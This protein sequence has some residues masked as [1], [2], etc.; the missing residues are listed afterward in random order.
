MSDD[1]RRPEGRR[2]RLCIE[3]K[4]HPDTQP[5]QPA[6]NFKKHKAHGTRPNQ[7][8][9]SYGYQSRRPYYG[10]TSHRPRS[11][12][13]PVAMQKQPYSG[14]ATGNEDIPR[15]A[16]SSLVVSATATKETKSNELKTLNCPKANA[17]EPV[18]YINPKFIRK[19]V[20]K[21]M[22]LSSDKALA[23]SSECSQ[24]MQRF[25][26]TF[27]RKSKMIESANNSQA[28]DMNSI[29]VQTL[30]AVSAMVVVRLVTEC[31]QN[32]SK[33]DERLNKV[34]A[35]RLVDAIKQRHISGSIEPL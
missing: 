2:R 10:Q 1:E 8:Q 11:H 35:A 13:I 30:Q 6:N 27:N 16:C 24:H 20:D 29:P 15:E 32:D 3:R 4:Q 7:K 21:S 5:A 22:Q 19:F 12:L 31:V 34:I 14:K 33:R 25:S 23:S 26:K 9:Q 18:I 28:L 17:N